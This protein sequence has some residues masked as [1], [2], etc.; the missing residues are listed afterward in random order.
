MKELSAF[1]RKLTVYIPALN[2]IPVSQ[3]PFIFFLQVLVFGLLFCNGVQAVTNEI[4]YDFSW[5]WNFV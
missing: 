2:I 1:W 3:E 4:S 5:V